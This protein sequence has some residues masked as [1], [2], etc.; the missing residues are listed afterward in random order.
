MA[1]SA[2][3]PRAIALLGSLTILVVLASIQPS[4]SHAWPG[5]SAVSRGPAWCGGSETSDWVCRWLGGVFSGLGETPPQPLPWRRARP[6]SQSTRVF[7]AANGLARLSFGNEA[8]CTVGGGSDQPSEIVARW[9]SDVLMR[10]VRG[11][12][13][14]TA[15]SPRPAS[16]FFCDASTG[17]CSLKVRARG[18]YIAQLEPPPEALA[19]LTE[20]FHRHARLVVCSGFIR[21]EVDGGEALG[22]VSGR[23]RFVITVDETVER[24]EDETV[25]P[26]GSS[27]VSSS[28]SGASIDVV[29]TIPGRGQCAS[30]FVQ[31]QERTVE[32]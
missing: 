13:S 23:N 5:K 17:P 22:S 30:S 27:K 24:T 18:T 9:E 12:A 3:R 4:R 25:T 6:V 8:H 19:S 15:A 16:E 32:G 1:L 28:A 14:C 20:S 2:A 31:S 29:G 26:N 10:V 21:V 7:T 11:D